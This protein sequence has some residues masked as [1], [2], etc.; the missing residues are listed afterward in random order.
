MDNLLDKKYKKPVGD[1]NRIG[2]TVSVDW[3]IFTCLSLGLMFL[4]CMTI[5]GVSRQ[6]HQTLRKCIEVTQKVLEC[7]I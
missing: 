4:L 5:Y 7:K 6:N 3:F 2:T 1:D